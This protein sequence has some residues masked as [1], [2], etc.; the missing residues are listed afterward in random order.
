MLPPEQWTD[1]ARDVFGYWEGPAARE[2]G[3]RSNTMMTMAQHPRLALAVLDLGKY[4][5][6]DSTLSPRQREL[7]VLRVSWRNAVDYEWAHHVHSARLIGMTDAEF[8]ALRS[9]D[10]SPVWSRED[11]A[12]IDAVDQLCG[13]GRIAAPTWSILCETLDRHGLMD[14]VYGIGFFTM[15]IWAVGT[16]GVS[17]EPDFAVFS[18]PADAMIAD[19]V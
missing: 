19:R 2:A 9:P 6:V 7:V 13:S 16:M 3:S 18:R 17:L 14:L 15:N 10:P 11:Q 12:L 1:A 8:D 5:L 4:M